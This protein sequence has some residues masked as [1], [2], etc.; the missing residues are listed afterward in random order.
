VDELYA[1]GPTPVFHNAEP[2]TPNEY[3]CGT[4]VRVRARAR[5]RA[6]P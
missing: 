2:E 1:F 3:G 6:K 5:V 4:L